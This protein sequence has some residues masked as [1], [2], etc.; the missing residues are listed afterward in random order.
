MNLSAKISACI[1]ALVSVSFIAIIVI[2]YKV[3]LNGEPGEW[4]K[5]AI[6]VAVV[7]IIL[8]SI[9]TF[10]IVKRLLKPLEDIKKQIMCAFDYVNHDSKSCDMIKSLQKIWKN[11]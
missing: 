9:L 4:L 3:S 2:S 5:D 10:V 6:I 1:S 11:G 8:G 7:A